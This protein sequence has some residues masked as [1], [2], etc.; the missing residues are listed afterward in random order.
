VR[1][2]RR[3]EDATLQEINDELARRDL[4]DFTL[5]TKSNYQ[6]GWF[7]RE[8]GAALDQFIEDVL[9]KRAP[10]LILSAPP[11]HGKSELT[12]R[13]MPAYAFGKNPDWRI[14]GTAYASDLAE[15][16]STDVQKVIDSEEYSRLFPK[17]RILALNAK[18]AA[19]KR[20]SDFFTIVGKAG[21]YRA[22]G[23]GGSLT[24]N[25]AD[26][27]IVDD[28][29]KDDL[30]AQSE[31]IRE[32][33]WNWLATTVMTRVQEG[34]G[35][36]VM[37]TRW[38]SDDIIG[39]LIDRE[40]GRWKVVNFPAIAE[41]DEPHRKAGDPLS[42]ERFSL[43]SLLA[44]R[45]GGLISSAQWAALYQGRP[46]PIGG[47]IFKRDDW[48]FYDAAVP[49]ELTEQI[50]SWDCA[51]KDTKTSD[52]VSGQVW[53]YKGA[54]KYLIDRV[55][56]RMSFGATKQ[57]VRT[58]SAKHPKSYRKFIE[59]KA[60][61][62]AVIDDMKAEISGMVPVEPE[63]GKISRAYAVS[64]EVEAHNVYL[65]G[66]RNDQGV[67]VPVGWVHDFIEQHAGFPNATHDDD[68]DACTQALAQIR[69]LTLTMTLVDYMKSLAA[70]ANGQPPQ[71]AATP[72]AAADT[73]N[74]LVKVQTSTLQKPVTNTQ[75]KACPQCAAT[76]IVRIAGTWKCN[77]CGHQWGGPVIQP[78]F[79][80]R[81][82]N[83]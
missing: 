29:L 66:R 22:V 51:F 81:D 38:H 30:E 78:G 8:V 4:V 70:A 60:N 50:Q 35:V 37:A 11:Q 61:G 33:S 23:R 52:F 68:V 16:F 27:V 69:K 55:N 47:N 49:P 39:R 54:N 48:R 65:P 77:A 62:T 10:R 43:E 67:L 41:V 76:M 80:R 28:P 34:G 25:P 19:E 82:L 64:G 40:K 44:S 17:T 20:R 12:S 1:S 73:S 53:G 57:A 46:S 79:S 6:A 9:A 36:I 45:D 42:V 7:H 72:P 63:G 58:M 31:T 21:S 71:T 83:K 56:D 26:I 13:R 5:T 14:V 2:S 3:L 24:G 59:D 32:G 75:T 74:D 18:S 15:S